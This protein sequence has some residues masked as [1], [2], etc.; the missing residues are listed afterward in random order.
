MSYRSGPVVALALAL[1][2]CDSSTSGVYGDGGLPPV[3][4]NAARCA[5]TCAAPGASPCGGVST[6]PCQSQCLTVLDGLPADCAQ[7]IADNSNW[8]FA[9]CTCDAQGCQSCTTKSDCVNGAKDSCDPKANACFGYYFYDSTSDKCRAICAAATA[10]LAATAIADKCALA[11][12][13]PGRG[14]CAG[15]K[16]GDCATNCV[17]G[18]TGLSVSCAQCISEHSYWD[19]LDCECDALG[20]TLTYGDGTSSSGTIAYCNPAMNRCLGFNLAKPTGNECAAAC[21]K[22]GDGGM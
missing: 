22:A 17:A 20:C 6:A 5:A 21:G 18:M 14:L 3:N 19:S 1:A 10:P 16:A 9:Q 8:S 15:T 13:V 4:P 7:C 12:V 11:C 2:A